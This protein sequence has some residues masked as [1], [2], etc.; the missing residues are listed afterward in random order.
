MYH[1]L[2]F[3]FNCLDL[4]VINVASCNFHA[5]F[6]SVTPCFLLTVSRDS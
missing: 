5:S 6:S 2:N 3:N 1:F 4:F